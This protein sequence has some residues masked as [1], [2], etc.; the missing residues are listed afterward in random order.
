MN[1]IWQYIIETYLAPGSVKYLDLRCDII[2]SDAVSIEKIWNKKLRYLIDHNNVFSLII[3]ALNKIS[4][5]Y[6][7]NS[8]NK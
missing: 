5:T 8:R 6:L 4:Y 7:D 2:N 1:E 3:I